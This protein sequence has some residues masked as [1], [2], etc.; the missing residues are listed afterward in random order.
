MPTGVPSIPRTGLPRMTP[1]GTEQ[2]RSQLF[3]SSPYAPGSYIIRGGTINN[4]TGA[5]YQFVEGLCLSRLNT[6]NE[7]VAWDDGDDDSSSEPAAAGVLLQGSEE[8]VANGDKFLAP[9][10]LLANGGL[11]IIAGGAG[12]AD[13][14]DRIGVHVFDYAADTV[15]KFVINFNAAANADSVGTAKVSESLDPDSSS[16]SGSILFFG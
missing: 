10:I 3:F 7:Y 5:A 4:D 16:G 8:A 15:A 9:V 11:R 14:A 2:K 12:D 13:V 1:E 6:A